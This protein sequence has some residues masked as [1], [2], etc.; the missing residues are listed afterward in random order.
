MCTY[1]ILWAIYN[2]LAYAF[3]ACARTLRV[4]RVQ[5][6]FV[7][8]SVVFPKVT[9][10]IVTCEWKLIPSSVAGVFHRPIANAWISVD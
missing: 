3:C 6:A 1:C 4:I 9:P 10:S 8:S 5:V 7:D 2:S